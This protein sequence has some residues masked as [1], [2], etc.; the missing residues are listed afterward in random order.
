LEAFC[1]LFMNRRVAVEVTRRGGHVPAAGGALDGVRGVRAGRARREHE[2]VLH[3]RR[4]VSQLLGH[5]LELHLFDVRVRYVRAVQTEFR[6][7]LDHRGANLPLNL[8][9]RSIQAFDPV[10]LHAEELVAPL[11]A[12]SFHDGA[13]F[14]P[15]R[16][17][18]A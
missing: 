4:H 1:A 11:A 18:P 7:R 2:R 8:R 5:L 15:E 9:E 16:H 13:D 6:P 3:L 10:H 12:A 14:V 17:E